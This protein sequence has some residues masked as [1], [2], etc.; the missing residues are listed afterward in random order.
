MATTLCMP[1]ESI[2]HAD[3]KASSLFANPKI[4]VSQKRF[5]DISE[6]TSF[7]DF[8]GNKHDKKAW[9]ISVY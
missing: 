6:D 4:V 9:T 1:P 2:C 7:D 3:T 8:S 5:E